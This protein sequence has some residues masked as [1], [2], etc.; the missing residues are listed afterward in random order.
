MGDSVGNQVCELRYLSSGVVM[1]KKIPTGCC[2]S[3][4][5]RAWCEFAA[6]QVEAAAPVFNVN[7]DYCPSYAEEKPIDRKK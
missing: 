5:N 1:D 7:M 4:K 3:C 2:Q 6:L